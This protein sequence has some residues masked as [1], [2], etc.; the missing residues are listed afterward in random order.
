MLQGGLRLDTAERLRPAATPARPSFRSKPAESLLLSALRY[1]SYE[2]PPTGK[3]PDAV[4]EDFEKWIAMGAPDPRVEKTSR[5][6]PMRD[7]VD[8]SADQHW[9]FQPPQRAAPPTVE[10]RAS[11]RSGLGSLRVGAA[12]SGRPDAVAASGAARTCCGGCTIDLTGLP[13]T[14][15]E[16]AEFAA[17]PSDAR[18]RAAVD[19]LLASPRFGERWARHWL[20]VA[21]YADTKGYVFEEDRNYKH[22]YM[23]RDWVIA[24]FNADRP[25]DQF[26]VA[27]LAADQ[28]DDPSCAPA[29]GFL[30][31]GRRFLNDQQ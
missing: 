25:F 31:L 3:L 21:R 14:A 11:A 4:I 13:P 2:M 12:R 30:T 28:V 7:A 23:Y 8:R 16:L 9:A 20:D 1:E 6:R 5:R 18:V 29:M 10:A 24:S 17:D 22:A 26:V 27:Q 19:R 15:A